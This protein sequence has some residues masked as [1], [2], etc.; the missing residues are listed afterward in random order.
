M[1]VPT[2]ELDRLLAALDERLEREPSAKDAID[3]ILASSPRRTEVRSLRHDPTVEAFRQELID[4]LI[5]V[6]TANRLLGLVNTVIT[7]VLTR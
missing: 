1:S 7:A 4:G 6:D 2:A 3:L 5:R